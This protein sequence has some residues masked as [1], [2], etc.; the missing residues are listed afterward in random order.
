MKKPTDQERIARLEAQLEEL[1][2]LLAIA[3]ITNSDRMKRAIAVEAE[4]VK[5]KQDDPDP[6]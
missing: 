6:A 2:H 4:R 1:A 5:P 3:L